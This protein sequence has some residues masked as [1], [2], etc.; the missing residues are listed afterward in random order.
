VKNGKVVVTHVRSD[1]PAQGAGLL[2]ADAILGLGDKSLKTPAELGQALYAADPGAELRLEVARRGA[3]RTL[4][5]AI[6]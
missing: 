1:G 3:R 5:L 6:P 4:T 2:V